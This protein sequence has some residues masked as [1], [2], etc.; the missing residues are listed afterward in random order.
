MSRVKYPQG[1]LLFTAQSRPTIPFWNPQLPIGGSVGAQTGF[2]QRLA[3]CSSEN[4]TIFAAYIGAPNLY[5][6][7]AP[8]AD[9]I[10]W[11]CQV[12]QNSELWIGQELIPKVK[13]KH[14]VMALDASGRLQLFYPGEGGNDLYRIQ[15]AGTNALGWLGPTPFQDQ[16]AEFLQVR[17]NQNGLLEMIYIGTNG[18]LYHDWEL[19]VGGPWNGAVNFAGTHAVKLAA[20]ITSDK[21][22]ILFFVGQDGRIYQ[23]W[24]TASNAPV[25]NLSNWNWAGPVLINSPSAETMPKAAEIGV[26]QNA[27][28]CLELFV[29]GNDRKLYHLTQSAQDPTSLWSEATELPGGEQISDTE[30]CEIQFSSMIRGGT[31]FAFYKNG[32]NLMVRRQL[33]PSGPDWTEPELMNHNVQLFSPAMNQNGAIVLVQGSESWTQS[34]INHD[35]Q[36]GPNANAWAGPLP[37]GETYYET[38]IDL[39]V[40]VAPNGLRSLFFI[41]DTQ[42]YLGKAVSQCQQS[43]IGGLDWSYVNHNFQATGKKIAAACNQDGRFEFFYVGTNDRIYHDWQL[44]PGGTNWN[45]SKPLGEFQGKEIAICKNADGRLEVVLVGMGHNLY[46]AW[47]NFGADGKPSSADWSAPVRFKDKSSALKIFLMSNLINGQ[48]EL[49]Y[50]GTNN[51]LYRN[52]Q[53]GPNGGTDFLNWDGSGKLGSYSGKRIVAA[54]HANGLFELFYI[55]MGDDIHHDWELPTGIWHG[56]EKFPTIQGKELAV[57]RNANDMLILFFLETGSRVTRQKSR[58]IS[59]VSQNPQDLS[60][61]AAEGLDGHG[62]KLVSISSVGAPIE[63]YWGTYGNWD[64]EL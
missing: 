31:L 63:L 40:A 29:V 12:A 64:S 5:V 9:E 60:W 62:M 6:S 2:F 36:L 16:E 19:E 49:F 44:E 33:A 18:K 56:Q 21:A 39:D 59:Y 54:Q 35:Q 38:V 41:A 52:S 25:S 14:L 57:G 1:T 48:L 32:T 55:G 45:G 34:V 20:S 30:V 28:G 10:F 11:T 61:F 27:D 7:G 37:I 17:A 47:Q 46:H 26:G 22:L 58:L 42:T 3:A 53:S 50:V 13:A 8:P 4:G 51:H 23:C 15:Q 24:Q 43:R